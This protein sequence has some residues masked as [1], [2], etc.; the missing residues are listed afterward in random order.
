MSEGLM[1]DALPDIVALELGEGYRF[2]ASSA[3]EGGEGD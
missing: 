3:G 1:G 2:E